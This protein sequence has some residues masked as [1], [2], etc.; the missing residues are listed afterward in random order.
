MLLTGNEKEKGKKNNEKTPS[1]Q[2]SLRA[3]KKK[4]L[5]KLASKWHSTG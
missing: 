2:S 5:H 4:N 1:F 3:K